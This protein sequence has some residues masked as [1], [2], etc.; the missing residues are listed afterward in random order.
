[1]LVG[2]SATVVAEKPTEAQIYHCG[3]VATDE[4]TVDAT[5]D[6]K[7]QLLTISTKSKGHRKHEEGDTEDCTYLGVGEVEQPNPLD[8][9]SDDCEV[10]DFLVGVATCDADGAPSTPTVGDSCAIPD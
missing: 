1:M 4:N 3:C 10:G 7:W 2:I 5:S 8:R 9:A 6:L